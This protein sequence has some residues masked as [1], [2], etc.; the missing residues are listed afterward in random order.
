MEKLPV[1]RANLYELCDGLLAERK[2]VVLKQ[3]R[4]RFL[5]ETSPKISVWFSEWRDENKDLLKPTVEAIR[6]RDKT[7]AEL[8]ARIAEIAESN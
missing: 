1:T 5:Q 2:T 6:E 7:I 4:K 8:K 3:I